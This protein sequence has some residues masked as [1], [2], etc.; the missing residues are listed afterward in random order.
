MQ[1]RGKKEIGSIQIFLNLFLLKEELLNFTRSYVRLT[2]LTLTVTKWLFT[3][4]YQPKL[5]Q[6][7]DF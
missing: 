6:K 5:K 4:L 7:Q 2:T 3:F 1:R